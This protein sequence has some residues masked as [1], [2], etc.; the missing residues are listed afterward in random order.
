LLSPAALCLR[1]YSPLRRSPHNGSRKACPCLPTCACCCPDYR[2]LSSCWVCISSP[3][4]ASWN[5]VAADTPKTACSECRAPCPAAGPAR[6]SL[7]DPSATS[8]CPFSPTLQTTSQCPCRAHWNPHGE[9][10]AGSTLRGIH[11]TRVRLFSQLRHFRVSQFKPELLPHILNKL[12]ANGTALEDP[13]DI[14]E[15][16]QAS[17]RSAPLE[18]DVQLAAIEEESLL[19]AS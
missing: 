2:S 16:Q 1:W 19:L 15:V 9:A 7:M 13:Q 10:C 17:D 4:P 18:R 5:A 6:A 14:R 3:P 11:L 12:L 8:G